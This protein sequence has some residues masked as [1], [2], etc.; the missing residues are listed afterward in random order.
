MK[1]KLLKTELYCDEIQ[2][3][4]MKSNLVI[5]SPNSRGKESLMVRRE[6]MIRNNLTKE[7]DAK[8]MVRLLKEK[9]GVKQLLSD[10]SDCHALNKQGANTT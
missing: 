3:R 1:E 10:V 9:I 8:M 6:K 4:S 5:S 7:N 2:Q